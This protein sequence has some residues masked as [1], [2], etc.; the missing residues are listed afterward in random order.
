M[1][2]SAFRDRYG[3]AILSVS[4]DPGEP[5]VFLGYALLVAGMIVVFT[6]RLIQYRN[7]VRN[8]AAA[9]LILA[10][11]LGVAAPA[12]AARVPEA[13]QVAQLAALPV[14]HDG[15]TMPFDTQARNA[16]WTVTGRRAWPGID[17]VAMATGW[18]IDPQGW[19]REPIVRLKS[20]VAQLAGLNER[21]ASFETLV[22]NRTLLEA[23]SAA[24]ARAQ[25]DEKP[26]PLDKHLM[27]VEEKLVTLVDAADS[28]VA[29]YP[30][31]PVKM[32][33]LAAGALMFLRG[34]VESAKG[35][36]LRSY[37]ADD[38]REFLER[39]EAVTMDGARAAAPDDRRSA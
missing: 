39:W 6:T 30:P 37:S 23:I 14:Q 31:D 32:A 7:A 19:A 16:V 34:D 3:A 10:A 8:G 36:H 33:Q 35:L 22:G 28:L 17:P 1:R 2:E 11:L 5:V 24:R 15:R 38:V 20:D 18:W 26:S 9:T 27:A 25:G 21:W 29:A 4:R 13:G 12:E